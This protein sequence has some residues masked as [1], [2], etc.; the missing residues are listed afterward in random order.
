MPVAVRPAG[1]RAAGKA[2]EEMSIPNP[3]LA[4]ILGVSLIVTSAARTAAAPTT[5]LIT[6]ARTRAAIG[7]IE[8]SPEISRKVSQIAEEAVKKFASDGLKADGLGIALIVDNSTP[9]MGGYRMDKGFY[10]ASVVKLCYGTHLEYQ[11]A[12]GALPRDKATLDDL[13]LMIVESSNVAT[14]RILDKL[15]GTESGPEISPE[16]L[17]VFAEKR[18]ATNRYM[19]ELGFK[20]FNACQKPWDDEPFGRDIQF[21]GAN[22]ENRNSM[23]PADTARLVWAI[24]NRKVVSQAGCD[25][26]LKY[27]S[28]VPGDKNDIQARRIG[29]GIPPSSKLWSKAGWTSSSNHDAAYVQP[30]F[31]T[32]F[33]L[34]VFTDTSWEKGE[35]ITWIANEVTNAIQLGVFE[36]HATGAQPRRVTPST[37]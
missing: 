25:E 8:N 37:H 20:G 12:K 32:P 34:T 28:R 16:E 4:A 30:P 6:P 26:I 33:V 36:P 27:M 3:V 17:K 10:P 11:F 24:K 19:K 35:I 22:Y 14:G 18:N 21:L 13:K 7:K 31:G 1:I 5:T 29:A 15:S 23:T 9:R 2:Q